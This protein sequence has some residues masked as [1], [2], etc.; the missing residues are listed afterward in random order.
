MFRQVAERSPEHLTLPGQ[1]GI[2]NYAFWS[3]SIV[4][5]MCGFYMWPHLFQNFFSARDALTIKKQAALIPVYN[6]IGW[7]FIMVGFAG[8][9]VIK[10]TDPDSLMIEM[11]I[12]S[13]PPWLVAFFSARPLSACVVTPVAP[14]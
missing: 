1:P 3:S 6:I 13:V 7:G 8:I 4:V 11:V 10:H 9:L 2:M 14:P 12:R 5:G